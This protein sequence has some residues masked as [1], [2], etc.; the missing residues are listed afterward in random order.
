MTPQ[1]QASNKKAGLETDEAEQSSHTTCL[2]PCKSTTNQTTVKWFGVKLF[3]SLPKH[4]RNITST[5]VDQFKRSLDKF[6]ATI[7]D[8]PLLQSGVDNGRANRSNHIFYCVPPISCFSVNISEHT[9]YGFS[10]YSPSGE[11]LPRRR[12]T[13]RLAISGI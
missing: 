7:E 5:P 3:N 4:I 9:T 8:L 6:L 12:T 2:N 11:A 13:E 10:N 1:I